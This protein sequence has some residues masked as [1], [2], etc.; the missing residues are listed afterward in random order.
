MKE[1]K[2]IKKMGHKP[3]YV[4]CWENI[5]PPREEGKK[6]ATRENE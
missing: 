6:K 4:G 1:Q 3:L 2:L 5:Q